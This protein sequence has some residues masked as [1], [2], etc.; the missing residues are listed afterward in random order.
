MLSVDV[1]RF[2]DSGKKNVPTGDYAFGGRV[3]IYT[4]SCTPAH[5]RF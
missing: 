1:R 4:Y 2:G 3:P 5:R